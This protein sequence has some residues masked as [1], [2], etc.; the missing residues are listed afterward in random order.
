MLPKKAESI[1]GSSTVV[2]FV[3]VFRGGSFIGPFGNVFGALGAF[4]FVFV[5]VV[6]VVVVVVGGAITVVSKIDP[7][8]TEV[9]TLLRFVTFPK[10]LEV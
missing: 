5:L 8:I 4:V 6:V 3:G 10:R 1:Q 2:I 7:G 9:P